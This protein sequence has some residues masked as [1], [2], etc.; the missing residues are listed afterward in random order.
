MPLPAASSSKPAETEG[1]RAC[2]RSV[3]GGVQIGVEEPEPWAD[4]NRASRTP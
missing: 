3:S 4:D 2:S 1:L